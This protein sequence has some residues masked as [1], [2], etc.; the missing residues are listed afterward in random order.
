MVPFSKESVMRGLGFRKL[1]LIS[2][3]TAVFA[4]VS[5]APAL[6]WRD[7]DG[8]RD[9]GRDRGHWDGHPSR[10][11]G[12]PDWRGGHHQKHYRDHDRG[13]HRNSNFQVIINQSY[14]RGY[15]YGYGPYYRSYR[16]PAPAPYYGGQHDGN[17]LGTLF[18]GAVGGI[19]GSQIGDGSGRTA[20]IIG[21]TLIGAIVGGN[22]GQS[23]YDHAHA[24]NV[25]E[26]T[27]SR[28]TV[29]WQNPDDGIAYQVTPMRT[30]Q[31]QSGQYCREYQAQARIGGRQEETFGT[32]CRTPDGDWQ[33]MN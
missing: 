31:S 32:A 28:Q 18:G 11:W 3:L 4:T 6:A 24:A 10:G 9:R 27:P 19:A 5:L 30:Y 17:L 13:H 14:G 25:F 33:I 26:V 21:G 23:P 22:I 7:D 15:D 12:P 20:A 8:R 16:R 29:A 2:S 1:F